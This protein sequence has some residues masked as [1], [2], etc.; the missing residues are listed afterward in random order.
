M[1][2]LKR[3]LFRVDPQQWWG[4]QYPYWPVRHTIVFLA[5]E[6]TCVNAANFG[7]ATC[8][9]FHFS[10]VNTTPKTVEWRDTCCWQIIWSSVSGTT[11]YVVPLSPRGQHLGHSAHTA[12]FIL[13][14]SFTQQTFCFGLDTCNC[15]RPHNTDRFRASQS[16][17][18]INL[19]QAALTTPTVFG[20][21]K[22]SCVGPS[23]WG[24]E[25]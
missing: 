24:Y 10:V 2:N 7:Y 6:R 25:P 3:C 18:N 5:V 1:Q 23:Q 12:S 22:C 14:D 17:I 20:R 19:T 21:T 15:R 11:L 16:A 9:L 13:T 8:Q 4:S